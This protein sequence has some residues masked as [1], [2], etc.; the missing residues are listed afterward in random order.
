MLEVIC[1]IFSI[2]PYHVSS[3]I[4]SVFAPIS[5]A[6]VGKENDDISVTSKTGGKIILND[7]TS[8]MFVA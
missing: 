3:S 1:T 4:S 6:Y 5:S 8:M 2:S 7:F